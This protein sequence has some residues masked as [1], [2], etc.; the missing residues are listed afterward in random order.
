MDPT[1]KLRIDQ[2]RPII[3]EIEPRDSLV[4]ISATG[5]FTIYKGVKNE[6]VKNGRNFNKNPPEGLV[7]IINNKSSFNNY[8]QPQARKYH[9]GHTSTILVCVGCA[10]T[11]K[12][13]QIQSKDAH[14]KEDPRRR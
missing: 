1:Q 13:V 9:R 5:F 2:A 3:L 12:H 14:E 11:S 10:K 8:F 7:F 4:G 6:Y